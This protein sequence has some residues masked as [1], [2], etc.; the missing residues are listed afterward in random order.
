MYHQISKKIIGFGVSAAMLANMVAL[1]VLAETTSTSTST[2]KRPADSFCVRLENASTKLD[3]D[4]AEKNKK[5]DEQNTARNSKLEKDRSNRD[6][7]LSQQKIDADKNLAN[8][9]ATLQGKAKNDAQA[10]ALDAF[11]VAMTTALS[12]R[13]AA[14]DSARN[15][16]RAGID[17]AVAARK[18]GM[19]TAVTTFQNALKAAEAKA[20]ADCAGGVAP[21]TIRTTFQA[22]VKAAR[23]KFAADRKAVEKLTANM[24]TLT[25]ARRVAM[26]KARVAFKV[27]VEKATKD[28]KAALAAAKP[29]VKPVKP[30][31]STI[32][33]KEEQKK[34]VEE[35]K[36]E[37]AEVRTPKQVAV[38]IASFAFAPASKSI[39]K[40]DTVTWTNNDSSPHTVT[41]ADGSFNSGNMAPGATFSHTFTSA[42]TFSYVCSYHSGMQGSIVVTE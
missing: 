26:E 10:K 21:A 38:T 12:A 14:F 23:E 4:M 1:P 15:T 31:T 5:L 17:S 25:T 30:A 24:K 9:Y 13:K 40:G 27:A 42:G 11:H 7:K 3:R 19:Q 32:I 8:R 28:L 29:V 37:T 22:E 16:F 18:A 2:P 33:K 20:K 6:E 41:A 34:M 35:R 39:S 36:E